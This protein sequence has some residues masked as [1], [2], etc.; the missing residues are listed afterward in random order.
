M[1]HTKNYGKQGTKEAFQR[2]LE[3]RERQLQSIDNYMQQ[4]KDV[5]LQVNFCMM[6]SE[7]HECITLSG[8][9]VWPTYQMIRKHIVE[10]IEELKGK[11]KEL[12]DG[13]R[14]D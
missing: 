14:N 11:L 2:G 8:R 12:E 9:G 5:R 6:Q 4:N 13:N 10:Q 1:G 7:K 3:K